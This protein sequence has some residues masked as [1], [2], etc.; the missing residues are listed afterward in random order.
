MT[1]KR[2]SK[3]RKLEEKFGYDPFAGPDS[4]FS[5]NAATKKALDHDKSRMDAF[6][7]DEGQFGNI[8]NHSIS[9]MDIVLQNWPGVTDIEVEVEPEEGVKE[10]ENPEEE[11]EKEDESE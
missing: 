11:E 9:L 5:R 3:K 2:N 8:Q 10:K 4:I 6:D 7:E 1:K